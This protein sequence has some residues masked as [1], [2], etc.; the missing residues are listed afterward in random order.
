MKNNFFAT[1]MLGI[2]GVLLL[3]A[4]FQMTGIGAGVKELTAE[5]FDA[6]ALNQL[7][8]DAAPQKIDPKVYEQKVDEIVAAPLFSSSRSPYVP[9]PEVAENLEEE[10][11]A[12]PLD[13]KVTSIVITNDSSYVMIQDNVSKQRITLTQGMPLEGDQGLWTVA[14]IEPRKVRFEAEGMES[15]ELELEVF[16]GSLGGGQ[17]NRNNQKK[18]NNKN[19][20]NKNNKNQSLQKVEKDK[21]ERKNSA[22][23]IRKKIAERRAEMRKKAAER[24]QETQ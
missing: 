5:P 1:V 3:V 2:I 20:R 11:P 9:P 6:K 15:V 7:T 17:G 8:E 13:A 23:E 16:S 10:M 14:A 24:N 18:K 12:S 22:E 21:D 19:N 4:A